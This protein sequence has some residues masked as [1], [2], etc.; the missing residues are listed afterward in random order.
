M[1]KGSKFDKVTDADIRYIELKLN[2]RPRKI[3]DY[4]TPR[5]VFDQMTKAPSVA[6][7]C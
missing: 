4:M 5:E 1:P 6:L 2:N 3:L 7:R